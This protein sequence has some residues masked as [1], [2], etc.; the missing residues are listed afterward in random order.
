MKADKSIEE[1][2]KWK[3]EIYEENKNLSLKDYVESLKND[4]EIFLKSRNI[5]LKKLHSA[6]T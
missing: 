5:E 3:D 4:S 6:H 2:W 1:V